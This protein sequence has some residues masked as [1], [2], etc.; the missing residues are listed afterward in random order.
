MSVEALV[1]L[2]EAIAWPAAVIWLGYL[3]R[4]EIRSLFGRVSQLKYKDLEAKFEREIAEAEKEVRALTSERGVL[5]DQEPVYPKPYDE[6]HS[7]LLR[8]AEESPRA[9]LIEAWIEVE[10]SLSEA[11]VH[12]GLPSSPRAPHTKLIHQLIEKGHLAKTVLPLFD[13][14][15]NMRNEAVHTRDFVPGKEIVRRY[16]EIAIELALTFRKLKGDVA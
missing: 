4:T 9:A 6:K 3:F 14:L 5:A 8:I 13:S 16:L 2:I 12:F 15:R 1:R 10:M 7:Q 11:A